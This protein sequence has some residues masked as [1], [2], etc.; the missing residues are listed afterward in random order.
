MTIGSFTESL[1]AGEKNRDFQT[2]IETRN[3]LERFLMEEIED[4]GKWGR[5]GRL[6]LSTGMSNDFE[7]AIKAGSESG[8][9]YLEHTRIHRHRMDLTSLFSNG[10]YSFA[11]L[12]STVCFPSSYSLYSKD[13][14]LSTFPYLSATLQNQ[15]YILQLAIRLSLVGALQLSG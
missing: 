2:V 1:S 3:F 5:D 8:A 9:G 15:K 14:A 10:A 6:V 12:V 4:E 11:F 13:C 7:A